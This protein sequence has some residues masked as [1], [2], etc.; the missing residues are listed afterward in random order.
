[1]RRPFIRIEQLPRA[2]VHEA[3]YVRRHLTWSGIFLGDMKQWSLLN[4]VWDGCWVKEVSVQHRVS[5][6]SKFSPRLCQRVHRTPESC[7]I[8]TV[9]SVLLCWSGEHYC[10]S[11]YVSIEVCGNKQC[12]AFN[13]VNCIVI[14]LSWLLPPAF[15]LFFFAAPFLL[16]L[17]WRH[18]THSCRLTHLPTTH[19]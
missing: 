8:F 7:R 10:T 3:T 4:V 1:M 6:W 15:P 19:I 9:R 11:V 13:I 16:C 2:C 18:Q 5:S 12:L 14:W 17:A